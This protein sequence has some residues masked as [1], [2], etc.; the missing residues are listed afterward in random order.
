M[1]ARALAI[2]EKALGPEH[3][4]V[5]KTLRSLGSTCS[6]QGRY[7]EAAQFYARALEL[8]EKTLGPQHPEAAAIREELKAIAQR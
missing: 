8:C 2:R 6:A 7:E 3:Q 1:L 4:L 5:G